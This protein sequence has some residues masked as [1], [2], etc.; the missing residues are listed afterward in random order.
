V[1]V[2]INGGDITYADAEASIAEGRPVLVAAGSGERLTSP[3]RRAGGEAT[4]ER[5]KP[6][7]CESCGVDLSKDSGQRL[8]TEIE[9]ILSEELDDGRAHQGKAGQSARSGSS[10]T[11]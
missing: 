10:M 9:R 6:A 5:H 8:S 1:T 11:S 4:P 7:D 3:Q 2:L